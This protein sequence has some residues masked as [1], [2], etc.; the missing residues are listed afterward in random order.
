[1]YIFASEKK[2]TN[3]SDYIS[4]NKAA[5][6]AKTAYHIDS[7][8]YDMKSFLSGKSSLKEIELNLLGD[9]K[10]K[11]ILH[12]QCH[13]GQDTLSLARMGANV[14]GVDLSDKAIEK[15]TELNSQLKLNAAFVCC[16]IYDLTQ[17]LKAKY[18][19][20]FT[21]YGTIGWLPDLDRWAAIVSQFLKPGGQFIMADFHP[22]VWMLDDE[23]L[24]IK[25]SY[26][27]IEEIIENESGTYAD[28]TAPIQYNTISWNHPSSEVLNSLVKNNL[29]ICQFD[30]YDYSPYNCFKNLEEYIPGKFRNITWGNKLPMVFSILASKPLAEAL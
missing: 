9:V 8:F 7:E 24:N 4:K 30:E 21:S 13:F 28:K 26:F 17:H 6:N 3:S 25:Y 19:I 23:F 5:W 2:M 11:S 27:N 20:V 22:V 18:D 29:V 15:A 16:D 1:M 12:L 10:G 14:T